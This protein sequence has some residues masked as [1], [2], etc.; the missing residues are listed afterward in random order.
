[1][2]TLESKISE[3]LTTKSGSI[4]AKYREGVDLI[5]NPKSIC[6]PCSWSRSKGYCN[7]RDMSYNVMD[8]LDLLGIDYETGNDAPKGGKSGDFIKLT[9]KGRR[10]VAKYNAKRMD[11]IEA[12]KEAIKAKQEADLKAKRERLEAL[13]IDSPEKI[14]TDFFTNEIHPAAIEVMA[15][16]EI[17]GGSWNSLR[18]QYSIK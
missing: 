16:K 1:M 7:L 3:R 10:Q 8:A 4:K 9:T 2:T 18:L 11:I 17:L 14:M 13:E 12:E 15:A 5:H 6:R